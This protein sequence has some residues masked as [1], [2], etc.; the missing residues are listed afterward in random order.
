M[1]VCA[2][3]IASSLVEI[4]SFSGPGPDSRGID[5]KKANT[6]FDLE[7]ETKH[8]LP[9]DAHPQPWFQVTGGE[10]DTLR[11]PTSVSEFLESHSP[12]CSRTQREY[13]H[14]PKVK[15]DLTRRS[16]YFFYARLPSIVF[17]S[18]PANYLII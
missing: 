10:K 14:E 12:S 11:E 17:A 1:C 8:I 7:V 2:R 9:R 5:Q 4:Q 13:I 16:C 15:S 18:V 3:A 6:W